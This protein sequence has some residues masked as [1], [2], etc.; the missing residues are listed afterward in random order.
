M[1]YIM[2]ACAENNITF[3]VLDRPN[4]NGHYVDGPVLD[5]AFSSFVG[6]HRVPVVHGMTIGEYAKMV[7]AEGWLKN[8]QQ[9]NLKVVPCRNYNHNKYYELPVKPSPNIPNIRAVYLY[10]SLCLFEGTPVSVGRGTNEQ[11]QIY[12]HPDFPKGNY[13][14]KPAPKV[15]AN[16]PLHDGVVCK[17]FNLSDVDLRHLQ[18]KIHLDLD[19]L[20]DF[21][22]DFP[23]KDKFFNTYFDK[24]A[25]TDKLR[26]QIMEGW[27]E[28]Q[29]RASWKDDLVSFQALRCKYLLYED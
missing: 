7:N 16:K 26:N 25:G 20:I 13:E 18:K 11:F 4:P 1:H 19:Y 3:M 22:Q 29:I 5:T 2:E 23:E 27:S 10:P 9:C 17:G 14:F 12:G 28:K 21:Y 24:L 6:L 15:G 8:A